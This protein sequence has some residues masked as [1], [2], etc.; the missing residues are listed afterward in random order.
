MD[1]RDGVRHD[2]CARPPREDR[3]GWVRECAE[4]GWNYGTP[5]SFGVVE[6][7]FVQTT[8]VALFATAGIDEVLT[9]RGLAALHARWRSESGGLLTIATAAAAFRRL[10]HPDAGEATG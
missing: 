1:N 10:D 3:R 8:A 6:P 4:G 7:P 5:E 9:R 2:R